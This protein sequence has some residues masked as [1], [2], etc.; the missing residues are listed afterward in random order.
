LCGVRPWDP[1]AFE[2]VSTLLA[3]GA[4]PTCYPPD[5]PQLDAVIAGTCSL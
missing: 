4:L 3:R 5:A 1:L 2:A